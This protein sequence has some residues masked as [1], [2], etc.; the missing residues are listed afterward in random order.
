VVSTRQL[1]QIFL[2]S[3]WASTPSSD[4]AI[5]K[6]STPMS[7]NRVTAPVASLVCSVLKNLMAGER[8]ANGDFRRL[9]IADLADHHDIGVLT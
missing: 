3:R 4:D 2:T 5:K 8:G 6:A 1:G 7:S 9:R